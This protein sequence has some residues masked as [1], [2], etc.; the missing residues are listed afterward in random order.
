[1]TNDGPPAGTAAKRA[2]LSDIPFSETRPAEPPAPPISDLWSQDP[3]R[4]RAARLHWIWHP[5]DGWLNTIAHH[6][7]AALP[8]SYVSG[9][10]AR[11]AP[12]AFWRYRRRVFAKR[13][14][15]NFAA[16]TP[17][18]WQDDEDKNAGLLRWWR[19]IGR[20][21][22]EFSIVNRLWREG[23]I[24]V[25]GLEHLE[26]AKARGGP[27]LFTSV[28]LATWEA[29]FVAIH[30]GFAGPSIGPFQPEPSRFTNRIVYGLRKA[31]NQYL[32]PPGQRS[33]FHLRRLLAAGEASMTIFIDEVRDR[34]V[35]FPCFGR[36][37]PEAGNAVVAIKLANA[38]GGTLVPVYLH[39]LDG[40]R[41]RLTIRPP[42]ERAGKTY[43][44]AE[45]VA[46][47]NAIFEPLVLA[48]IEEWYMLS[49]V[50]LPPDF[51]TGAYATRLATGID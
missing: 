43:P 40:A 28:H 45:T 4:K 12:L 8:A 30:E 36:R 21:N 10:G 19:N 41:F 15:R 50:R 25:A 18:R 26:A 33:A 11:L 24:E 16:L 23:R 29:V 47:L 42:L 46:A 9:F 27:V 34:Q 49:E 35:H 22:A 14:A 44:V 1:M 5:F 32:F 20:S 39:R 38:T 7:L 6:G 51:E 48:N 37:M 3:V 31:R 13:I 2:R 17:G